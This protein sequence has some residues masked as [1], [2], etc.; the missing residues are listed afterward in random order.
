MVKP[1]KSSH[2]VSADASRYSI[3]RGREVGL[4]LNGHHKY[5]EFIL[6]S[7][8]IDRLLSHKEREM[9]KWTGLYAIREA[10][11]SSYSFRTNGLGA[12]TFGSQFHCR[13]K[14]LEKVHRRGISLR[15]DSHKQ[16][17][18]LNKL[19]RGR[20]NFKHEVDDEVEK[21]RPHGGYYFNGT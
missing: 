2:H 3:K 8:V 13:L 17:N 9:K 14:S 21:R 6:N 7:Y 12:C 4:R 18:H 10:N 5:F 19:N 1:T 15:Q 11:G 16:R 20:N